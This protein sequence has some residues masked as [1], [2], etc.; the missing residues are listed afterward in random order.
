M[1]A[2]L[3]LLTGARAPR[4]TMSAT[5]MEDAARILDSLSTSVILVDAKQ[6]VLHMNGAAE[7]LLGA[8][9]NQIHGKPLAELLRG[10]IELAEIIDRVVESQRPFSRREL[11]L[12]PA[13]VEARTRAA[14]STA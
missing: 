11:P 10:G 13:A 8:S 6:N 5:R 12:R 1:V 14:A 3:H 2:A 9:R 4:L 7:T